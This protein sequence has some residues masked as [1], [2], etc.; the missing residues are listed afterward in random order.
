MKKHLTNKRYR[1]IIIITKIKRQSCRKAVT[2]SEEPKVLMHYGRLVASMVC[3]I[4]DGHIIGAFIFFSMND[5]RAV[6]S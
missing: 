3:P 2:Q 5:E 6:P 4:E 1:Y